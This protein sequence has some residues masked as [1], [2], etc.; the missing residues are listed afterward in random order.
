MNFIGVHAALT[1]LP[2]DKYVPTGATQDILELP[3]ADTQVK[4]VRLGV[5]L[6]REKV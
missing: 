6:K 1:S 3:I 4:I 5:F 2:A